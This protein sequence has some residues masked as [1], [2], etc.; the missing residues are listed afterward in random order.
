MKTT[1]TMHISRTTSHTE[2]LTRAHAST[3]N[4]VAFHSAH[5]NTV[6]VGKLNK[7][8]LC[9]AKISPSSL[10]LPPHVQLDRGDGTAVVAVE[11]LLQ[12]EREGR[13]GEGR[14]H[15][16]IDTQL[17]T[18]AECSTEWFTIYTCTRRTHR[19]RHARMHAP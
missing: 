16:L 15:T 6:T 13:R 7:G 3:I 1:L 2:V 12:R 8:V 19:H 11:E 18:L 4:Y 10:L 17:H 5:L 9:L 14:T